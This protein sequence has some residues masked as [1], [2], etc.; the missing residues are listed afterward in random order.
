MIAKDEVIDIPKAWSHFI[1]KREQY[2]I[3][4]MS[5]SDCENATCRIKEWLRKMSNSDY[6][7]ELSVSDGTCHLSEVVDPDCNQ[8]QVVDTSQFASLVTLSYKNGDYFRGEFSEDG[9]E[10]YGTVF[11]IGQSEK[12]ISGTWKNDALE[13]PAWEESPE[14][15][16]KFGAFIK[17]RRQGIHRIL[18]PSVAEYHHLKYVTFFESDVPTGLTWKGMVGGAFLLGPATP[19]GKISGPACMYL[20]PDLSSV[21]LGTFENDRLVRGCW[22]TVEEIDFVNGILVPKVG[23]P[24]LQHGFLFRDVSTRSSISKLPLLQD[25]WESKRVQVQRSQVNDNAGEGLFAKIQFQVGDLICLYNGIRYRSARGDEGSDY[26][27]KLNSEIDIDIPPEFTDL[28]AYCATSGHKSNH[29]FLPNA[30]WATLDHVRFGLI[31]AVR[32]TSIIQPG[33]EIL[34][35]YGIRM[36]IAPLSRVEINISS[37]LLVVQTL[38]SKVFVNA[39]SSSPHFKLYTMQSH[40][41]ILLV[42]AWTKIQALE[43]EKYLENRVPCLDRSIRYNKRPTSIVKVDAQLAVVAFHALSSVNMELISDIYLYEQWRDIRCSFR[44]L[45]GQGTVLQ[46]YSSQGGEK[47]HTGLSNLWSPDTQILNAKKF[48]KPETVTQIRHSGQVKTRTRW[49]VTSSCPMDLRLFPM[50]RQ[51][52]SLIIQSSAHPDNELLYSWSKGNR[53]KLV[54]IQ[55]LDYQDR[56][57]PEIRLIG[58]RFSESLS[59]IDELT[60]HQYSQIIVDVFL[61]RPL[62]YFL[63]EVYMPASF[64][65]VISFTS[66]WLDRAATPARVSLGVTT[67]LTITTLLSSANINLP[68]TAYPKSIGIFLAGCF[69][70]TFMALIEY[71]AASFLE[72]RRTGNRQLVRVQKQSTTSNGSGMNDGRRFTLSNVRDPLGWRPSIID[73]YSRFLFPVAF[74]LFQ[75]IY[76][77]TCYLCQE[78]WP[79]DMV[80]LNLDDLGRPHG[81]GMLKYEN[82]EVFQGVF[83]H[84]VLNRKGKLT[85][86]GGVTIEGEWKD[87]L[88]HG[89]MRKTN[90]I[91]GWIEGYWDQGVPFGFQREFGSKEFYGRRTLKFCGRYFRGVRRGFCWKGCLGGGFICGTVDEHGEFTG[92]DIAFIYPDFHNAIKGQFENELLIQGQMCSLSFCDFVNGIAIPSF[93]ESNGPVISY[94]QPSLRQIARNPLIPDHWEKSIVEVKDSNLPQGGDGLFAKCHLPKKSLICLFNG[95]RMKLTTYAAEHMPPSDYRIRL[96]A[97]IDLD[98]PDDCVSL[99]KYCATLGHKANHSLTPNAEWCLV[100]HPR[101]GLIRGLNSQRD[102]AAGEEILVNY[103]MNL[104]DAPEWYQKV[105]LK[106]QREHKKMNDHSIMRYLERYY[107]DTGKRVHLDITDDH[108]Y[109]PNPMGVTSVEVLE[110]FQHEDIEDAVATK[111]S[112]AAAEKLLKVKLGQQ[113]GTL[114]SARL[115]PELDIE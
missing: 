88:M 96:N 81:E 32:A 4:P 50:D 100:E 48:H 71:S 10:R 78:A 103:Q 60:D 3:C 23:E 89:E 90:I 41:A 46:L 6:W 66:F 101:F 37:C 42:C 30:K 73:L 13:G 34:V 110:E 115:K 80:L 102:I 1:S 85:S 36:G 109:V 26:C 113:N 114:P 40:I 56:M 22:A 67:V 59:P 61:E 65:V 93:T 16:T 108:F 97:D 63:W 72:R 75:I 53:S 91:G 7:V 94:E 84:G 79:N 29:S 27:I 19:N 24:I 87:G 15:G 92:N 20:Y 99:K 51:R 47:S 31:C 44:G 18:G 39:S 14:N 83:D 111:E 64:I 9:H 86:P 52:C 74:L 112:L 105:W 58:Y 77:L 69:L 8:E 25:F 104:A 54:F 38:G 33:D 82:D 76:W 49:S 17:G 95:I 21:V 107:D 2:R 35:N 55:G 98:I 57:T 43:Q 28:S 70:F 5:S 106:H 11:K 12:K 62:G 68:P 45:P